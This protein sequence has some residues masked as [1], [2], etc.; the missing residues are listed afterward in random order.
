MEAQFSYQRV[1]KDIKVSPYS[2]IRLQSVCVSGHNKSQ[3]MTRSEYSTGQCALL[4][5]EEMKDQAEDIQVK[6][7]G[8]QTVGF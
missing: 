3:F 4:L 8:N 6:D 7:G 5:A 2:D 1:S